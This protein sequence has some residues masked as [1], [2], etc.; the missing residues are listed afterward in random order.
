MAE[1]FDLI[2]IG[3][4]SGGVAASRRAA[5]H[6]ARVLIVEADR[7]GGTCV[8]RGCVPKKLM[9]Y[10]AGFALAF[11]E[12]RGYGWAEVSG[13]FEMSRWADAKA[14]EIGRLEGIYRKMLADGG[15][16][17]AHGRARL[18]GADTVAVGSRELRARRVLVAT[19]G[20]PA[21]D[22]IPGLAQALTSNDVLE[23][24][25]V[26]ATL[27]VVGGGYI[28]VEFASILAGL[29][30]K[31]TLALRDAHP[32]RGFDADL[33]TRL[34]SALVGRGITLASGVGLKSLE[35]AADDFA[36]HRADGSVLRA[37]T[38]LNATGRAPNT[39]GIGLAEAGVRLDA[40]GAIAVDADSRSS[41]PGIWAIGDVTN[42]VN[43]TPVAIAEGRAFADTEFGKRPARVDHRTVASAVFTEPPIAT[44]GLTEAAAVSAGPVDIY[45]SDFRSMKTAFA[46]GSARTYM[47]LV[48]DGLSERVLGVHM[49]GADA[50]EIVQSLAVAL[51]CGATKRDF[52]RT[53]AVHPTAAK[54]FV[55]MRGPVRRHGAAPVPASRT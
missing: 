11:E 14:T 18:L 48:V 23:L 25:E 45:E 33:R 36:L 1:D 20:A 19:G 47:K 24:R 7:V 27:L 15:V 21:H 5:A 31:V 22:A 30:S 43:L 37:Q 4:G 52:D 16:E 46:G 55:L 12:A 35:R 49:I 32:L 28:A 50:P 40:R 51:T 3:A 39:A 9:M 34:A 53:I 6:G 2:V 38:A 54:E 10:A 29:G 44:V 13:R 26:P 42:R 17:L 8:I 41:V